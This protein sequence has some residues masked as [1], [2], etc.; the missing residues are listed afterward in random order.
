VK[1][2][3]CGAAQGLRFQPQTI[4]WD[5][6]LAIDAQAIVGAVDALHGFADRVELAAVDVRNNA[7]DFT[8]ARLLG[9]V[10]RVLQQRLACRFHLR[11]VLQL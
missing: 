6:D 10:V 4:E 5:G 7:L 8:F 2:L 3:A 9:R 11:L 1:G